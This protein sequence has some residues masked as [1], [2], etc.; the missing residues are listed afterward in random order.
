MGQRK[1]T[2]NN[3]LFE[4]YFFD[5]LLGIVPSLKSAVDLESGSVC[6]EILKMKIGMT[7][8]HN[9]IQIHKNA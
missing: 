2:W 3:K 4:L 7:G 6:G 9:K 8:D 5:A 1:R